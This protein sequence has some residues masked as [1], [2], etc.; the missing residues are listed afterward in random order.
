[1]LEPS[2]KSELNNFLKPLVD[3]NPHRRFCKGVQVIQEG[4]IDDRIFILIEG[5][6]RA[7]SASVDGKEVTYGIY[8]PI[9]MVGEMALDG[10]PRSASVVAHE[11]CR[12]VIV[13]A[14]A[15]KSYAAE[16]PPFAILLMKIVIQRARSATTAARN[17]A[18]LDVYGRLRS[19]LLS[20]SMEDALGYRTIN[21][22]FTQQQ[23]AQRI[24]AS[25]EMVARLLKDL[26][27]GDY[28]K[29]EAKHMVIRSNIPER[30]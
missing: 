6:L 27:K 17:L 2:S 16:N 13:S 21:Q 23:I 29:W 30:W 4:E 20:Q 10:G 11:D 5:S 28:L 18:L 1:M 22:R 15:L 25:R 7:F 3:L 24:G 19:F 8:T 9:D 14:A 26:E 12:C